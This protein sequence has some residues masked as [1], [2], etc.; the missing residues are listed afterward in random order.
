MKSN[1]VIHSLCDWVNK[2]CGFVKKVKEVRGD[3]ILR[4]NP[5]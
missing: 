1:D 5:V 3:G 2:S 4:A